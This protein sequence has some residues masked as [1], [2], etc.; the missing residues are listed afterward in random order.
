M[1][2][3]LAFCVST[4][5]LTSPR[6]PANHGPNADPLQPSTRD[7]DCRLPSTEHAGE[8]GSV[9]NDRREPLADRDLHV[10]EGDDGTR[11]AGRAR[12]GAAA[13]GDSLRPWSWRGGDEQRRGQRDLRLVSR[14]SSSTRRTQPPGSTTHSASRDN[15]TVIS[16]RSRPRFA[17]PPEG[18]TT[19][20]IV[21]RRPGSGGRAS[22]IAASRYR[23]QCWV[24]LDGART[25]LRID[26]YARGFVGDD[27]AQLDDVVLNVDTRPHHVE[28]GL[29]T[30]GV[31]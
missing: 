26:G 11:G 2:S 25:I 16:E 9:S 20:R 22:S 19:P 28:T 5:P 21:S 29:E 10:G 18:P 12:P 3:D 31:P 13:Q 24:E 17:V 4:I 1:P 15:A 27:N 7:F 23:L 30:T 14:D 6:F 8:S